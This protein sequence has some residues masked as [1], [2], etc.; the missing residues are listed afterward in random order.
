MSYRTKIENFQ[1]FGN[2]ESYEEW[3]NFIKSQGI[4]INEEG[5]YSGEIKDFM[6]MIT[7][8]ENITMNIEKE[9]MKKREKLCNEIRDLSKEEQ[10]IML[11]S[12][13]GIKSIFD[14]SNIYK[15]VKDVDQNEM[16]PDSLFDEL[17]DVANQGYMFLAYSA[18]MACKDKI[19]KDKCFA[20]K[21]HFNCYKL[22][23]GKT[24]SVSAG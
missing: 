16:F 13:Y 18:Y 6:G 1:I 2:N 3:I 5:L 12:V 24:I 15:K 23:E 11:S 4:V 22:K 14:L 10:E 9:R 8:L 19:E 21:K 7:V 17:I 20:D